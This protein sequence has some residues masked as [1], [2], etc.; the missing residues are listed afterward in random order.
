MYDGG[1]IIIV[2]N[3]VFNNN[4]ADHA[5]L[6]GRPCILL[7]EADD[8]VT[9]LPMRSTLPK[10]DFCYNTEIRKGSVQC[11]RKHFYKKDIS[12]VNFVSIFQRE[13][14]FY[15]VVARVF[16]DRYYK[17]I[18]EIMSHKMNEVPECADIYES[19]YDDLERQRGSLRLLLKSREEG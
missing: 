4:M 3:I 8:K 7:S 2:R 10:T 19:I 18:N 5:S 12:Y 1:E 17:L 16:E 14:R 6:N 15:E 9:F 11:L 13:T